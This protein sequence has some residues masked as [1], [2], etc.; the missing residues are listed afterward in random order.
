MTELIAVAAAT[1][2]KEESMSLQANQYRSLNILLVLLFLL[3][4][5]VFCLSPESVTAGEGNT[6]PVPGTEGGIIDPADT[7]E[8]S[9]PTHGQDENVP[10]TELIY[11]SILISNIS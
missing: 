6:N 3:T 1:F 11:L 10:D 7:N 2:A 4:A 9:P 5:A 8:Y